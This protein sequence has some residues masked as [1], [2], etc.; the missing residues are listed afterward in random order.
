MNTVKLFNSKTTIDWIENSVLQN[1][2]ISK[3]S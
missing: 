1:K 2:I 3:V